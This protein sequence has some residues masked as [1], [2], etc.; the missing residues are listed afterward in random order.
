MPGGRRAAIS[1]RIVEDGARILPLR[2]APRI[3]DVVE[4]P[5]V[6]DRGRKQ[7][8][9]R[10]FQMRLENVSAMRTGSLTFQRPGK[11]GRLTRRDFA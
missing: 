10:T 6:L 7:S 11:D 2:A 1:N 5:E 4:G 9:R 3:L 8:C